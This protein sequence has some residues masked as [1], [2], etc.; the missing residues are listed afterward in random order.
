[1]ENNK[2]YKSLFLSPYACSSNSTSIV[3]P[4]T[5]IERTILYS[6]FCFRF[7]CR[8]LPYIADWTCS[9]S[10]CLRASMTHLICRLITLPKSP[11]R[12][13]GITRHLFSFLFFS[14]LFCWVLIGL[15]LVHRS[16]LEVW[17]VCACLVVFVFGMVLSPLGF[18]FVSA[19]LRYAGLAPSMSVYPSF[20]YG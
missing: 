11:G 12:S 18:P 1:M 4:S 8:P 3:A 10:P 7:H 17:C 5:S 20:S 9:C 2:Y 16:P 13:S 6:S 14:V 15:L 19:S